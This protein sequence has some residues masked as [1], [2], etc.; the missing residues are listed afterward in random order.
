MVV[1]TIALTVALGGTALAGPLAQL[2][3]LSNG[4]TLIM[5]HSLSGDRLRNHTL[6]GS[7]I[8]LSKLGTVPSAMTARRAVFATSAGSASTANTA[9]SAQPS[10]AAG[11]DLSGS[12]PNPTLAAPEAW[13]VVGAP[14]EPAFENG[15]RDNGSSTVP[16]APFYK[17]R[18]GV[19]HPEGH[20]NAG[21]RAVAIFRLPPGYRPPSGQAL[22]FAVACACGTTDSK[23]DDVSVNTGQL[24]VEGPNTGAGRDGAVILESEVSSRFGV[25][26]ISSVSLDGVS[27]RA[28]Q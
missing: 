21:Q 28:A 26:D 1:A 16:A 6:T 15:W 17:D 9:G 27:F 5:K 10:G 11:G 2:A 14:G 19:V 22:E 12:Y 18:D 7:Q 4:N 25:P 24:T 3:H 13:H 8:N 23:N 20:V